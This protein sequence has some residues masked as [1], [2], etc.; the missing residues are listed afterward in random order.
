MKVEFLSLQLEEARVASELER[1]R[2]ELQEA[3]KLQEASWDE[4]TAHPRQSTCVSGCAPLQRL[5]RTAEMWFV[6]K[7][8]LV[9]SNAVTGVEGAKLISAG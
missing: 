4:L 9:F 1:A 3:M 7:T 6:A 5:V 8:T 2:S